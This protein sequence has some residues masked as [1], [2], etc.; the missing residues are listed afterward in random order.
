MDRF[1]LVIVGDGG[2]GK[3]CLLTVFCNNDFPKVYVP[4][5]FENSISSITV[6]N[7][8]VELELWDT[9]GQEDYD[10]LRPLSY[11]NSHVILVCF[12][13]DSPDSL[14]NVAEK[15]KPEINHYM[16]KVPIILVGNKSDL[17]HDKTVIANLAKA[18]RAPLTGSDGSK[19][20]TNLHFSAF[21]ACSAK[22]KDGVHEVFQTA[23][24]IA[25]LN[26]SRKISTPCIL[27]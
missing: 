3:T 24:R 22:T 1:K 11:Q 23:A 7:K 17:I 10:R 12:A 5:I 21:L 16:P 4:T 18:G 15:W 8:E 13:F 19:M 27:L 25:M 26:K 14:Q 6:D 9:A 20:A 2:S